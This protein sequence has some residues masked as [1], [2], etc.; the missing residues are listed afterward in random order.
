ME[1]AKYL[2]KNAVVLSK[3]TIHARR[4]MFIEEE[5]LHHKFSMFER[6]SK[7]CQVEFIKV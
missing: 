5:K 2:L 4:G 1:V 7:N 6:G 3:M